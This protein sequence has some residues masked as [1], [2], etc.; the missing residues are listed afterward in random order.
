LLF[1]SFFPLRCESQGPLSTLTPLWW[2][3][4]PT[5]MV[6]S[7]GPFHC[8]FV[9]GFYLAHAMSVLT[10]LGL[11]KAFWRARVSHRHPWHWSRT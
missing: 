9:F 4:W 7:N 11:C 2:A 3:F 1:L 6:D 8:Q 5:R 10:F